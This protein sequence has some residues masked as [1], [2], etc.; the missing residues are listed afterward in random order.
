MTDDEQR[1]RYDAHDGEDDV[2]RVEGGAGGGGDE[3][4]G[5]LKKEGEIRLQS[6]TGERELTLIKYRLSIWH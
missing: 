1:G 2:G 3:M 5:M 4:R 6:V